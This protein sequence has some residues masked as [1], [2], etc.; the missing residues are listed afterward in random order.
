M[1]PIIAPKNAPM[2]KIIIPP[3]P[4]EIIPHNNPRK[5]KTKII[6]VHDN[7]S[8]NPTALA[9]SFPEKNPTTAEIKL[10]IN[11][12]PKTHKSNLP[13]IAKRI[14]MAAGGKTP[15]NKPKYEK[16][17]SSESGF[18]IKSD[19]TFSFS[20][21]YVAFCRAVLVLIARS[22]FNLCVTS[23]PSRSTLANWLKL[24][25][26]RMMVCVSRIA[27][28]LSPSFGRSIFLEFA[29]ILSIVF[30]LNCKPRN[31]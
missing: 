13:S 14:N 30:Q 27:I 4:P 18:F 28:I 15:S 20:E 5:G 2:M 3:A 29:K 21:R 25:C 11:I 12:T 16:V 7:F 10:T 17:L 24:N 8:K 22:A 26:C 6:V 19:S 1:P 31:H 9:M 23:S